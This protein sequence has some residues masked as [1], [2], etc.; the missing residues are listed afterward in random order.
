MNDYDV[1]VV[2]GGPAGSTT[3]E[4]AALNGVSVL[5]LEEGDS[6]R[7]CGEHATPWR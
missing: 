2:G 7:S 4:H 1:I 5:I 6:D 3:A